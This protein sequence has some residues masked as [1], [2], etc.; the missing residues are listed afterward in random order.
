MADSRG[1]HALS[2]QACCDHA[3]QWQ[4]VH[5]HNAHTDLGTWE[6]LDDRLLYRTG[7]RYT[8]GS[9]RRYQGQEPE[10]VLAVAEMLLEWVQ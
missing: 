1:L 3:I 8:G 10:F 2:H 9:G 6:T 7:T 4:H 5:P